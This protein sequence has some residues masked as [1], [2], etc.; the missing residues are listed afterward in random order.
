MKVV[1][2]VPHHNTQT[3]K[4]FPYHLSDGSSKTAYE[5]STPD[6]ELVNHKSVDGFPRGENAETLTFY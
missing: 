3:E 5:V 2:P 4:P 1:V 6:A